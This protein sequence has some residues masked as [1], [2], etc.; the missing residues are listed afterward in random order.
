[1]KCSCEV[2]SPRAPTHLKT[3]VYSQDYRI[4][5]LPPHFTT[6]LLKA[7]LL[8]FLIVGTSRLTIKKKTVSHIEREKTQFEETEQASEPELDMARILKL[9]YHEFKNL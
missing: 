2:H 8:K 1:M 5:L 7:Y 3:E 9:S 4:L 6:I